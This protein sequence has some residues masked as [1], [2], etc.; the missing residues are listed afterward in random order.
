MEAD[1]ITQL[2]NA[3]LRPPK[4]DKGTY[5]T[6]QWGALL[7][8][9]S[10][11]LIVSLGYLFVISTTL[12]ARV[13]VVESSMVHIIK[14]IDNLAVVDKEQGI[15]LREIHDDQLRRTGMEENR[16]KGIR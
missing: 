7:G 14:T 13:T 8:I 6:V 11:V 10:S 5:I 9:I 16:R 12:Q 3:L 2:R 4:E 15:L 1:E